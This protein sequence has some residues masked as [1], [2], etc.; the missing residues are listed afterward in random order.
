MSLRDLAQCAAPDGGERDAL[1]PSVMRV[2]DVLHE[3]VARERIHLQRFHDAVVSH[4]CPP[5]PIARQLLLGEDAAT[6]A[7]R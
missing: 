2:L 4:G 5:V 3:P 6:P 7:S 1:R